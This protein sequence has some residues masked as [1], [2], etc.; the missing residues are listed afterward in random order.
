MLWNRYVTKLEVPQ[1]RLF[2][3]MCSEV[4]FSNLSARLIELGLNFVRNLK[5]IFQKIVNPRPDFL[6]LGTRELW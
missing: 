5:L 1:P 3:L 4:T 6:D 2:W